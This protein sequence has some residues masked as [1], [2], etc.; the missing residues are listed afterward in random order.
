M[1]DIEKGEPIMTKAYAIGDYSYKM[2]SEAI[3][4]VNQNCDNEGEKRIP[5]KFYHLYNADDNGWYVE[6]LHEEDEPR[7]ERHLNY[8]FGIE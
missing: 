4:M 6:C 2:V 5:M 7:L 1:P 8:I 3:E